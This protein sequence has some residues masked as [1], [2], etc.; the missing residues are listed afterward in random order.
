[1]QGIPER[2]TFVENMPTVKIKTNLSNLPEC[3]TGS[4][5]L[6]YDHGVTDAE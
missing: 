4:F 1:M 5:L 3:L 6:I 2:I